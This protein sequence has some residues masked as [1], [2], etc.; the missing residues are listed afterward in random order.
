[1]KIR[2]HGLVRRSHLSLSG[3][4]PPTATFPALKLSFLD[5]NVLDVKVALISKGIRLILTLS[6]TKACPRPSSSEALQ[7]KDPWPLW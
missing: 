7:V 6:S 5:F 2:C 1:M 3:L 4:D